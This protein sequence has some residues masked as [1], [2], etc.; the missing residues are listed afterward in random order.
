VLVLVAV[1]L[2]PLK[3]EW[4]TRD[5]EID[6]RVWDLSEEFARVPAVSGP[7]GSRIDSGLSSKPFHRGRHSGVT[8][9]RGEHR[10]L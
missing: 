6:A 1:F 2:L 3:G 10:Y 4:R 9:P 7:K 5:D 8:I